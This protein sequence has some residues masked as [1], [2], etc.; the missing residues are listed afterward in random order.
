MVKLLVL[1]SIVLLPLLLPTSAVETVPDSETLTTAQ[2]SAGSAF[3]W[4]VPDGVTTISVTATG[5]NGGSVNSDRPGGRGAVVTVQLPV[6][7]GAVLLI[8][9]GAD[10]ALESGG[11]GYGAGGTGIGAGGGGGSTVIEID[12][13]IMILAGA[14]GGSSD[15]SSEGGGG[16]GGTP[17]GQPGTRR[18]GAGGD[19]GVGGVG[20]APWGGPGGASFR[21]SG[22]TV[23]GTESGSG[24]GAGY[25][26]GGAGGARGDGGGGGSYSATE[27]T[28][29]AT[30]LDDLP[31]GWVQL[32]FAR[33]VVEPTTPVPD[34]SP[35][36][37][38]SA[39]ADYT[40]IGIAAA[41]IL[42]LGVGFLIVWRRVRS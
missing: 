33:T 34:E 32:D 22:G 5:G 24:G 16:A 18:G 39:A 37:A 17:A 28:T 1:S 20:V 36:G 21:G 29:Y 42:V 12:G 25:G 27:A 6:E 35:T 8:T 11:A 4:V 15:V 23:N 2:Q 31:D 30:R 40:W 10:G 41:G 19:S 26:G 14:G 7:P 38:P 13:D 3:E 9:L